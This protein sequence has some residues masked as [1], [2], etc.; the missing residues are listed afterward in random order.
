MP[1]MMTRIPS[2]AAGDCTAS[3]TKPM[4]ESPAPEMKPLSAPASFTTKVWVEKRILSLR[5][6][7]LNSP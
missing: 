1:P 5:V 4:Q 6:P 7:S 2:T 3:A